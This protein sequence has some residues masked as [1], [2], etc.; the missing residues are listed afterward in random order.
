MT[1]RRGKR[2]SRG[3]RLG[4]LGESIFKTWALEN[5]LIPQ[6]VDHDYGVDFFAQIAAP[7]SRSLEEMTGSVIAAQ[8]RSVEGGA[9]PRVKLKQ[10][11]I[12]SALRVDVPFCLF[13]VDIRLKQVR[14]M[15]LDESF[16]RRL[17]HALHAGTA[18]M[19]I[20]FEEFAA[21]SQDFRKLLAQVSRSGYR[22][23][24]RILKTELKL[25]GAMPGTRLTLSHSAR[26]GLA[27]VELPW[28]TQA[29]DVS[30]TTRDAL[31]ALIFDEGRLPHH[32]EAGT[33]LRPEL[34]LIQDLVEGPVVLS[35]RF[36]SFVEMAVACG[37]RRLTQP[38]VL[39]RLNDESAYVE[40]DSGLALVVSDARR[41]NDRYVH[42]MELRFTNA[43]AGP[44]DSL[45]S[46]EFLRLLR[47]GATLNQP[48]RPGMPISW[49]P[50]LERIGPAIDALDLVHERLGLDTSG[51][52]LAD[53]RTREFGM[54][55]TLLELLLTGVGLEQMAPAFVLG[56]AAEQL[57]KPQQ[58][59]PAGFRVPVIVNFKDKGLVLW[60][61]GTGDL[62]IAEEVICGFRIR[63]QS[64]W[65]F[66]V[67]NVRFSK[68]DNPEILVKQ[69]WPAVPLFADTSD[70]PMT[71]TG[72]VQHPIGGDIWQLATEPEDQDN[73]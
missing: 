16:I 20:K 52:V 30:S 70:E 15:F 37:A 8:I 35:G 10:V 33:H 41:R 72:P 45:A 57:P 26:T 7:I 12:E 6:K 66:D 2:R 64:R 4:E 19:S 56:P 54:T 49:W 63:Q 5:G 28:I 22:E 1:A 68:S 58:W 61:E 60:I 71:F 32:H 36:E 53:L 14:F 18:T 34:A 55:L 48:G 47:P 11:D 21:S 65:E 39:R 3:Q 43:Q 29:F 40:P 23:Q 62:Y 44:I 25:A 9:R 13:A 67:S 38:F 73:P 46:K 17:H 31:A 27:H 50:N 69:D 42:E 51:I 24:L 59:Y